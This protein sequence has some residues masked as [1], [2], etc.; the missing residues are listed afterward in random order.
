MTLATTRRILLHFR[1]TPHPQPL[2]ACCQSPYGEIPVSQPPP[3]ARRHLS[4]TE[5]V[6]FEFHSFLIR[7]EYLFSIENIRN[8]EVSLHVEN[9]GQ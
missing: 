9:I 2:K 8:S 3:H 4:Y 7:R 5:R 6:V 1:H